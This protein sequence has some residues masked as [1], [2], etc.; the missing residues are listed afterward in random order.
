M[1]SLE[2]ETIEQQYWVQEKVQ[3]V[4][5][6]AMFQPSPLSHANLQVGCCQ[7]VLLC[8]S[9]RQPVT[10]APKLM[11]GMMHKITKIIE[12]N[13]WKWKIPTAIENIAPVRFKKT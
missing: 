3:A 6:K 7:S 10:C 11:H 13:L 2:G 12:R 4:L 5:A 1:V 9:S 8:S